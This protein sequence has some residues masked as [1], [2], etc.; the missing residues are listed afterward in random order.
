MQGHTKIIINTLLFDTGIFY[1]TLFG[2][3]GLIWTC[4]HIQSDWN[5][6]FS[7]MIWHILFLCGGRWWLIQDALGLLHLQKV[8]KIW[9]LQF[10]FLIRKTFTENLRFDQIVST[11]YI[12][13]HLIMIVKSIQAL[14]SDVYPVCFLCYCLPFHISSSDV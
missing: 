14:V 5:A 9:R 12:V 2:N 3:S 10:H 8:V 6:D 7:T 4:L 13:L 11:L 1:G